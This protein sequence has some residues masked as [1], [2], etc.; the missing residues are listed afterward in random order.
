MRKL[1]IVTMILL[2]SGLIFAQ[3]TNLKIFWDSFTNGG[4]EGTQTPM[5]G[6]NLYVRATALGRGAASSDMMT[7]TNIVAY[8][9]YRWID[10]DLRAPI[11][12]IDSMDTISED[13]FWLVSWDAVDTTIEDGEGWGVWLYTVQYAINDTTTWNTWLDSTSF[14]DAYFGPFSPVNV[15]S[16]PNDTFYFR[17]RAYDYATNA[18]TLKFYEAWVVYQPGS[19]AFSIVSGN[20]FSKPDTFIIGWKAPYD[21]VHIP[22]YA[23]ADTIITMEDTDM[24]VLQND[25][26]DTLQIHLAAG[27]FVWDTVSHKNLWV[28]GTN[29]GTDTFGLRAI[30]N[31]DDTVPSPNAFT[32]TQTALTSAFASAAGAKFGPSDGKLMPNVSGA[33]TSAFR[34]NLWIQVYLPK[35]ST[36]Y[37]QTGVDRFFI[38]V[39]AVEATP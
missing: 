22:Y 5:S 7:G 37:G 30:L 2:I 24:V 36:T 20:P 12:W 3:A 39:K 15:S 34:E 16:H 11:S 19:L 21:T 6:G 9:G 33:D 25:G 13:P 10:L 26:T 14:T 32:A 38:K 27:T 8:P 35:W 1:A 29:G 31:D 18:E 4:Y 17:V 23:D 28:L